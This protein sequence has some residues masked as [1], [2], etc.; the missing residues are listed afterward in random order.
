MHERT[1]TD[2]HL[3]IQGSEFTWDVDGHSEAHGY[4][5]RP[6]LQMLEQFGAE[7]VLDLG[8]GNGSLS[9]ELARSG[10]QV[11]G[12]DFSDS[13]IARAR[14]NYPKVRFEQQD[15][16]L[17]LDAS[18]HQQ[19]DAVISTEVIEHLLLPRKL[20]QNARAALKPGGLFIVTTP[21]HG[22]W[23]N[24][25]L[26]LT[27]G[28]DAHWHPLRDHG[29]IKFFSRDTLTTLFTESGFASLEFRTAGRIPLIAKSMIVGGLSPS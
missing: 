13:G 24:L 20:M 29:H 22:Y 8:C 21:F 25:L 23:K 14:A 26:A 3:S 4:I 5:L 17:P 18:Y 27:N 1:S 16:C 9:N 15:L 6:V 28:F 10:M 12:V 11:T 2:S 19:F 7:R